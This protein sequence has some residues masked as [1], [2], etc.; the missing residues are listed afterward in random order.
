MLT[1]LPDKVGASS[2]IADKVAD[3]AGPGIYFSGRAI[4]ICQHMRCG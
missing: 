2:V 3:T 4:R 1:G